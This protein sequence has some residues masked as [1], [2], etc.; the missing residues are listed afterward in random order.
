MKVQ[1]IRRRDAFNYIDDGM[2]L[3][4]ECDWDLI[5]ISDSNKEKKE[6]RDA[7]MAEH[8]NIVAAHFVNFLD[9]DDRLG[10]FTE[11]KADGIVRFIT[12]THRRRKNLLVHC[13]LGVSRSGAVAK[14]AHDYFSFEC[15]HIEAYG[16]Y[17]TYVYNMLR[18]VSGF[19]HGYD[20]D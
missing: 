10:G 3:R 14:F 13:W 2:F 5:S 7:W 1:F 20:R 12:E 18:E 4:P 6:I 15:P 8:N 11:A 17:N 9:V 19:G 16:L